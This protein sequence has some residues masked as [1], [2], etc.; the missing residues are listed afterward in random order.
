M[1]RVFR[2]RKG[3]GLQ[4]SFCLL[5]RHVA[6]SMAIFE[7]YYPIANVI[8]RLHKESEWMSSIDAIALLD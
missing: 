7:I 5:E 3:D 2:G 1:R 4:Q 8:S 6:E